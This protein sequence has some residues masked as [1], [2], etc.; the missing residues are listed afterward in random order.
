M[1]S[2]IETPCSNRFQAIG[3]KIKPTRLN[4]I[5]QDLFRDT[6]LDHIWRAQICQIWPNMHNLGAYL[7]APNMVKWSVPIFE[8]HQG[9]F[10]CWRTRTYSKLRS[11]LKRCLL[12]RQK[13]S[14]RS[15]V[16]CR[17]C[18]ANGEEPSFKDITSRRGNTT[19]DMIDR[20]ELSKSKQEGCYRRES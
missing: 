20:R 1:E 12:Q 4:C 8:T 13:L 15:S 7:G 5:L 14:P 2:D 19:H 18:P 9:W 6:P 16:D 10:G 17:R 3:P 11:E